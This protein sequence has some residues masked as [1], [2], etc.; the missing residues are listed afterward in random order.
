M[1]R[2]TRPLI[3]ACLLALSL[4][5]LSA[6]PDA[7][8]PQ[9]GWQLPALAMGT[10]SRPVPTPPA[11][12]TL[13]LT[14]GDLPP[15]YLVDDALENAEATA[16]T[17][18]YSTTIMSSSFGAYRQRD[19]AFV[20]YAALLRTRTD[21]AAFLTQEGAAVDHTAGAARVTLTTGPRARP[22]LA[23]QQRGARGEEWVMAALAAGPYVAILG[24]YDKGG[25]QAAIDALQQFIVIANARLRLA[26][27]RVPDPLPTPAP[28]APM[29]RIAGLVTTTRD[30]RAS[31]VFHPR[32]SLYWRTIWRVARLPHQARETIRE[33]VWQG[34]RMLYRNGVTDTPYNGVNEADDHLTLPALAPGH[35]NVTIAVTIG[36]LSAKVTHTFHVVATPPAKRTIH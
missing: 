12:S 9:A 33:T 26:A 19:R 5:A 34:K 14:A 21:A 18:A 17:T 6:I 16:R 30:G 27:T 35:Y 32:S 11:P 1:P 7:S 4:A 23:Y 22:S 31:D 28:T 10:H 29:L 24:A 36:R 25:E 20:Q 13:L 2:L 3:S 8:L 15:G